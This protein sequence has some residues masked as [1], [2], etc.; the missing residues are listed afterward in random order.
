[1]TGTPH[2]MAPE[3][4]DGKG[5]SYYVDLWS[6][7][8]VLYECLCGPTPFG[9][10]DMEDPIEIYQAIKNNKLEFPEFVINEDIKCLI[11]Q[12]LNKKPFRRI[13]GSWATL[14]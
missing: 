6:L 5:Y 4:T 11:S 1:M 7:G 2:Y 13:G 14:K 9:T 10:N 3:I 8:I 12:F